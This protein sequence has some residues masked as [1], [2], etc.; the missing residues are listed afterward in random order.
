MPEM[1]FA[2]DCLDQHHVRLR[3]YTSFQ[4]S[5]D[6]HSL[7]VTPSHQWIGLFREREFHVQKLCSEHGDNLGY[8]DPSVYWTI[9]ET[10][11]SEMSALQEH[12][13]ARK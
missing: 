9:V 7:V 8:A 2:P 3:L 10:I 6:P 4:S 13:P 5:Q 1:I 11:H 12:D